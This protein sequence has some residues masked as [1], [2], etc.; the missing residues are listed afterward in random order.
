MNVLSPLL[1][2]AGARKQMFEW[3]V[4][5]SKL[6]RGE[7]ANIYISSPQLKI[8]TLDLRYI[9]NVI[10]QSQKMLTRQR[11]FMQALIDLLRIILMDLM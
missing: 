7:E 1:D 11:Y 9:K 5:V 10:D 4:P 8:S 3:I 6:H 2:C